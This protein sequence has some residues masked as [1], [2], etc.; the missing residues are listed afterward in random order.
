MM[1]EI[2]V[3]KGFNER[4]VMKYLETNIRLYGLKNYI[5]KMELKTSEK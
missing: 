5:E 4:E 1:I 3:K 2:T